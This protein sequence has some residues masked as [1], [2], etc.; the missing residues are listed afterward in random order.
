ML[1]LSNVVSMVIIVK[2]MCDCFQD[3]E[4]NNQC[5]LAEKLNEQMLEQEELIA[6]TRRDFENLQTEMARIQVLYIGGTTG[7]VSLQMVLKLSCW[8]Y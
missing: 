5:Q 4:I 6:A 2:T 1:T 7:A 3:D 8:P